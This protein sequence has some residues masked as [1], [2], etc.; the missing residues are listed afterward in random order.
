MNIIRPDTFTGVLWHAFDSYFR[1]L[2]F[3]LLFSVPFLLVMPLA[4]FLPNF[5]ALGGIFFRLGSIS[6]DVGLFDLLLIAGAFCV[7]LLI[8]SFG[9][10]AINMVVKT[11]R[12]LKTITFYE[13]EKIEHYTFNLFSVFFATFLITLIANLALYEYGLHSTLGALISLIASLVV[14]FAPQAIV[15]DNQNARHVPQMSLKILLRKFPLFLSYLAIAV[16]LIAIVTQIFISLTPA[17]GNPITAELLAVAV[18]G[19]FILP[20]LEVYKTQIY[21]SKYTLL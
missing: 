21:L 12:T 1:N 9:L 6:R 15:I 18:N 14:V 5:A 19:F 13:F 8:F 16:A 7:S 10:V 20:F 4:L 2:K 11:E 17:I 3:L